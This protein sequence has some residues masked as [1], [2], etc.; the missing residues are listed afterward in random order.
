MIT[1]RLRYGLEPIEAPERFFRTLAELFRCRIKSCFARDDPKW[2]AL[3][4][5]RKREKFHPTAESVVEGVGSDGYPRAR[6]H[7][8]EKAG[9]TVVF[10]DEAWL[11]LHPREDGINV[12]AVLRIFLVH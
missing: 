1:A 3:W 7:R 6:V 9:P 2:N 5:R 10:L 12:Y 11:V 4:L 8:R